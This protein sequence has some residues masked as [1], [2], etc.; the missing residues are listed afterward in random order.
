[1]TQTLY[2]GYALAALLP[3][4]FQDFKEKIQ[5]RVHEEERFLHPMKDYVSHLTVAREL[6]KK[7]LAQA[8]RLLPTEPLTLEVGE[9][10][11]LPTQKG[12]ALLALS[13][14]SPALEQLN[15]SISELCGHS[16]T[17]HY[18]PHVTLDC[19]RDDKCEILACKLLKH[20]LPQWPLEPRCTL[21]GFGVYDQAG[22]LNTLATIY[23]T[24][25]QEPNDHA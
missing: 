22:T 21:Q 3:T 25:Q 9:L 10:V 20:L 13:I 8:L 12:Y 5:D 7:A 6:P 24:L 1:M 23:S 18:R 19:I 11:L 4:S 2:Q 15:R 14:H 16:E 17:F